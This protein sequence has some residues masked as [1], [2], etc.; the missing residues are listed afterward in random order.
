MSTAVNLIDFYK[1]DHRSQYPVGT[2]TVFSNWTPR[3]SRIAGI[4]KVVLFGL[5]Y[6]VKEYLISRWN[7]DFFDRPKED[8][9]RSYARRLRQ[10]GIEVE[11]DHITAL[12]E[13]GYLPI[14]IEAVP[15][16]T[17]VPIGV[18]MFV[19]WNTHPEFF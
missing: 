19:M 10:A 13:L 8:V 11:V 4:N 5:Q 14:E 15:E 9:V 18:P 12:H 2:S 3:G 16:G 1:A 17:S 6:F 7:R